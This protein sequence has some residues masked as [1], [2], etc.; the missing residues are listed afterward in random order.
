MVTLVY[1]TLTAVFSGGLQKIKKKNY[2][3]HRG[4]DIMAIHFGFY[5]FMGPTRGAAMK[6]A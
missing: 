4:V 2:I 5:K 1:S 3:L 6:Q